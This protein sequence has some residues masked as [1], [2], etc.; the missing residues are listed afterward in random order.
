MVR[1][2]EPNG[3]AGY[4]LGKHKS[5][6]T[7]DIA[8]ADQPIVCQLESAV[9]GH[10][11]PKLAVPAMSGLPPLATGQRASL[12]VRFV[13]LPDSC[14]AANCDPFLASRRRHA[15]AF[16]CWRGESRNELAEQEIFARRRNRME[17]FSGPES[18]L[19]DLGAAL[20]YSFDE[21]SNALPAL[22]L[23]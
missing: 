7:S 19:S 23:P 22:L 16:A 12:E 20:V 14:I 6:G 1:C 11:R 4:R 18:R 5:A 15:A 17:R 2:H 9:G 10:S 21:A 8:A 13:P 3:S